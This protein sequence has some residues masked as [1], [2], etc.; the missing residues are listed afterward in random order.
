[1]NVQTMF[2]RFL[3][4]SK[5]GN[6]KISEVAAKPLVNDFQGLL[7]R[8]SKTQC[9]TQKMKFLSFS[10]RKCCPDRFCVF[11]IGSERSGRGLKWFC[12]AYVIKVTTIT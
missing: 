7:N 11:L 2:P 5:F 4:C 10:H 6:H 8:Q 3:A 1:M 12:F 9:T